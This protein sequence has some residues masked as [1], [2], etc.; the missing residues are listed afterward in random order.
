M[1][2]RHLPI[3]PNL[4]QLKHQ[5]K[6]LLR[7]IRRGEAPAVADLRAHHP[8]PVEPAA[9]RLA[10]AQ[11]VLAR[12]YGVPSWPRL[13]LACRMIEA[14]WHDEVDVVRALVRQHTWP[15]SVA[16]PTAMRMIAERGGH[17]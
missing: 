12:S 13:V 2:D 9:A 5:A 3:R 11:L 6:D 16:R 17:A 14:I 8:E 10:D 4:D 7:A 1:S 15:W